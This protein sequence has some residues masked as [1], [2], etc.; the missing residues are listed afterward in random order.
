VW[1]GLPGNRLGRRRSDRRR[2]WRAGPVSLFRKGVGRVPVRGG[3][4]VFLPMGTQDMGSVFTSRRVPT[5]MIFVP[6]K[7]GLS[8]HPMEYC[9]PEACVDG[10]QVLMGAVLR[11]DPPEGLNAADEE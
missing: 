6:C 1:K 3:W 4:D 11:Y 7:D 8:H 5:S 9:S 2:G 10:S